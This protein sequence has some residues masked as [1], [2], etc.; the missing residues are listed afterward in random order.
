MALYPTNLPQ[1]IGTSFSGDDGIQV[2]RSLSGRPRI[3][4]YYS[5]TWREGKII[6]ELSDAQLLELNNFYTQNKA[7]TFTFTFQADNVTY[8]C[9]FASSPVSVPIVGGFYDVEVSIIQVS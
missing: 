7:V 5:Q 6:H 9:N 2:S 4:N 1:L 8:N 3:R